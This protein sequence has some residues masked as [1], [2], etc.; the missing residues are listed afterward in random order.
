MSAHHSRANFDSSM[1]RELTGTV[2]DYSWRNPHVD[3]GI[4]VTEDSGKSR[5]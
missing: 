5:I 2:V 4:E 1:V 3:M